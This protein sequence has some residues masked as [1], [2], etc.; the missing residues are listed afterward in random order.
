MSDMDETRDAIEQLAE[1]FLER[2]RQGEHPTLAEY[3][4]AYP[5]WAERIRELFPTMLLLEGVKLDSSGTPEYHE[6]LSPWSEEGL[7]RLGDF[8]ILREIGRGGMGVVYEAIQE[9]LDRH[10]ALK[11]L[12][13]SYSSSPRIL[14]RFQREAQAAA[15]LHHMNIVSVFG[16]GQHEGRHFYVME[17]IEGCSLDRVLA[18]LARA[19]NHGERS[20]RSDSA[21]HRPGYQLTEDLPGAEVARSLLS[22]RLDRATLA[23]GA[24]SVGSESSDAASGE[25]SAGPPSRGAGPAPASRAEAAPPRDLPRPNGK[26]PLGP[27]Y[28]RSVAR[29]G[30]Q[31]AAALQ[32]AHKQ[33]TLHRDIK[34]GNL[35]LDERRN[36]WITDF[37]LAKFGDQE[38]I[39]HPGDVVGT[40]RYMAPEQLEGKTD[41]RSDIYSLGLTLY[42]LLTLRPAFDAASRHRLIHQVSQYEPPRPRATA[43]GIPRDLETIVMKAMARGP[44]H[45]Y[46][47]AGELADDL[48]RFLED[49]PIRARRASKLEHAW[50]WCRRNPAVAGLGATALLLLIALVAAGSIGY[51]RRTQAL[52]RESQLRAEAQEEGRRAEANSQLAA[53][54]FDEVFSKLSGASPSRMVGEANNDLWYSVPV[55]VSQRDAAVLTSLLEFYDRFAQQNRDSR[56]WEYETALAFRRVGDIHQLLGRTK[57]AEDAYR[58]AA[59]RFTRLYETGADPAKYVVGLAGVHNELGRLAQ[60][61][62]DFNAALRETHRALDLLSEGGNLATA[63]PSVRF[64]LARTYQQLGFLELMRHFG[65]DAP[66]DRNASSVSDG[67]ALTEQA[68]ALLKQLAAEE[69][70]NGE[71]RLLMARCYGHLWGANRFSGDDRRDDHAEAAI[72][73]LEQLV[74]DFP[75]NPQYQLELALIYAITSHI[76]RA[77]EE[78]QKPAAMGRVERGVALAEKLVRSY[79]DVPNYRAVLAMCRLGVAGHLWEEQRY[80]DAASE[81]LQA[82]ELGRVLR[83]DFPAGR[84][85]G[86]LARALHAMVQI[87]YLRNEPAALRPFLEELI[88]L[89]SARLNLNASPPIV[90]STLP[91]AYALLATTLEELGEPDQASAA[92][93]KAAELKPLA[94]SRRRPMHLGPL[95]ARL[96]ER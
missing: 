83:H 8:R 7:E 63:A 87:H 32:Y 4:E 39:T 92:A 45:R 11:V 80:D 59:E 75:N 3:A 53:E 36:V 90:P 29:L 21:E 16:V 54:A 96:G 72:R 85:S 91:D 23:P 1:E 44:D 42:E 15:R 34:P 37:G 93:R 71:Y 18:E 19:C 48:I 89:E 20:G 86:I 67:R 25:P 58:R 69:P 74:D 84:T 5:V 47:T 46:A 68:L 12:P 78:S 27:A 77:G 73:L 38:D 30:A 65:P 40:L 28:W 43:P 10:V 81:A 13:A 60:D 56:R 52:A 66:A 70:A 33:G 50:R 14:R 88:A 26:L 61:R 6:S 57:A 62:D 94:Q 82:V 41:A 55:A 24:S 2:Y 76:S 9:S 22:G 79:P 31:A 35:M 64:E 51:A 49:R 17:Y 95:G